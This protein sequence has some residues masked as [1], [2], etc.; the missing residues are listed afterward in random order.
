MES[1]ISSCSDILPEIHIVLIIS[2][3]YQFY[4][5]KSEPGR[6]QDRNIRRRLK[7]LVA[8]SSLWIM[9]TIGEILSNIWNFLSTFF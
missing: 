6:R 1:S 2:T 5:I 8:Q 4:D 9:E 3:V 7:T